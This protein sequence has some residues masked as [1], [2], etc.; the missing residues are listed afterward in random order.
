MSPRSKHNSVLETVPIHT[1]RRCSRGKWKEGI[2]RRLCYFSCSKQHWG[3]RETHIQIRNPGGKWRM[4]FSQTNYL[5]SWRFNTID[6]CVPL[7]PMVALI[8]NIPKHFVCIENWRQ[9]K[10]PGEAVKVRFEELWRINSS[11]GGN[12]SWGWDEAATARAEFPTG[13]VIEKRR[14][15]GW[16]FPL[17][18]QWNWEDKWGE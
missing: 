9:D 7:V 4:S 8:Q 18:W 6:L 12:R 14:P 17:S 2:F 11:E 1:M 16:G 10:N 3:K 15:G 13:N 5:K